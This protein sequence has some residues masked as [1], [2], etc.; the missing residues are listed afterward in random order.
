LLSG[1]AFA[2]QPARIRDLTP[3]TILAPGQWEAKLFTGVY[4]QTH[5]FDE[6]G[7]RRDAG[8][9]S[10]YVTSVA[11]L[12]R[13]VAARWNA[14]LDVTVRGVRD[15]SFPQEHQE[16]WA[17]ASLAPKVKWAPWESQPTL[18]VQGSFSI[19][20]ASAL[21]GGDGEPF[22]DFGDPVAAAQLFYDWRHSASWLTYLEQGAFVRFARVDEN[23]SVGADD[24]FTTSSKAIVNFYPT[25][26]WTTYAAEELLFDWKR[27]GGPDWYFQ[28][29]LGLKRTI[30]NSL[31]LELLGTAF[32][33]GRNKGAGN[34]LGL[35]LRH[36]R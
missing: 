7:E 35:G 28:T 14:G 32:P 10:T 11:S 1:S 24:A 17:L 20:V 13:G 21:A 33:W 9:R 36:V 4:T 3:S 34:T 31:E 30:G 29:G 27:D 16:R 6:D 25:R 23:E 22:L 8:A 19:P 18:S 26:A 5:F 12:L 2:E 15:E